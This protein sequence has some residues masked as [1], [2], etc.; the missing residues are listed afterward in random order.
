[1]GSN[2]SNPNLI[3]DPSIRV[4]PSQVFSV[5]IN[6]LTSTSF[7]KELIARR[8]DDLRSLDFTQ[9]FGFGICC[10]SKGWTY[11]VSWS[12]RP[13]AGRLIGSL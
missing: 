3:I 9:I 10:L 4:F 6:D 11:T 7:K 12:E 8:F 1:M 13:K 2:E 5:A